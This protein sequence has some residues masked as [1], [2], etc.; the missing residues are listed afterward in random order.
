[1]KFLYPVL[2]SFALLFSGAV[3]NSYGQGNND[4]GSSNCSGQ[5]EITY[6]SGSGT[7]T[8]RINNGSGDQFTDYCPTGAP[9]ASQLIVTPLSNSKAIL[10]RGSGTDT[11]RVSKQFIAAGT[12]YTFAVP[13]TSTNTTYTLRND[14]V[15][16]NPKTNIFTIDLRPT[17]TIVAS[18]DG[19]PVA[20]AVC[21]GT[22]V[23]LTAAGATADA[24]YYLRNSNSATILDQNTTGIF[25]V[26]PTTSSTYSITT[27][28]PT[29]GTADVVQQIV[30]NTNNISLS[31][32]DADN[33]TNG[34]VPVTLTATGGTAG[35]YTWTAFSAG[36]TTTIASTSS[37]IVQ[38]PTRTTQYTVSGNTA[39]GN[40]ASAATLTIIVNGLPL[41]VELISFEATWKGNSPTLTWATASEKNNAY[42]DVE[43]SRDGVHAFEVVG[44]KAG[45]GASLT[46]T[47]YQFTD[48][49]VSATAGTVYYRLRQVDADGTSS[50]SEVRAVQAAAVARAFKAEV[51]PNP[52]EDVVSVRFA[53]LGAGAVTLTAH[54]VMGQVRLTQTVT[55]AGSGTQ[56]VTLP[57]MAGLPTGVYYLTIRQGNQQ[58]VVKISHR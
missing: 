26:T 35:T 38:T 58:Q 4:N 3:T 50:Y 32:N 48:A 55:Y 13:I 6:P 8:E 41:P 52:F 31:S 21:P 39:M 14:I 42:F 57:Q 24:I 51:F 47:R 29:C 49:S 23:T 19:R 53:T 34:T 45:V 43:R 28:T 54:D 20:G 44:R 2:G 16:N 36:I 5:F 9:T 27:N 18:V 46:L 7:F 33:S 37:S 17:L 1:M 15:C 25:Q 12:T 10:Y 56:E 22:N 11:V 30:V 40:C